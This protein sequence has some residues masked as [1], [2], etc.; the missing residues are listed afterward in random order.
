MKNSN[1]LLALGGVLSFCGAVFQAAIAFVPKWSAAYG[2]GDALV[3][4][5]P[6]L[7]ALGLLVALLL[8]VFGLYGFSGAGVIRRLPLLRPVLLMIGLIYPLVGVNFIFQMLAVLGILPSTRPVTVY[9]LPITFGALV[10]G[11]A[12]LTGL[13]I[14]WRRLSGITQTHKVLRQA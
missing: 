13:A 4:N 3:S 9:Q 12:Y 8:V 5:P 1:I 14:S 11:L 2:A 10:A 6:L 7:L